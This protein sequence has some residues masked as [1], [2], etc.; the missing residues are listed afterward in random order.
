[1][2]IPDTRTPP[3]KTRHAY[4]VRVYRMCILTG[5]E[6]ERGVC[7]CLLARSPA[8]PVRH[9][10]HIP[11]VFL[12]GGR[13]AGVSRSPPPDCW[14]LI[15]VRRPCIY[16]GRPGT[17]PVSWVSG[18]ARSLAHQLLVQHGDESCLL[19]EPAPVKHRQ[20]IVPLGWHCD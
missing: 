6:G 5:R 19:G 14:H 12:R 8:L 15:R 18:S 13:E 10:M 9:A 20:A 17:F 2:C 16:M 4:T 11:C 7:K 3:C 1:M